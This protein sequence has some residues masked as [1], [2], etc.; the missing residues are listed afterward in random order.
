MSD[1]IKKIKTA[2]GE[3]QIDYTALANLPNQYTCTGQNEDGW[4]TQKAVTDYLA[5]AVEETKAYIDST[6]SGIVTAT[7]E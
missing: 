5:A 1:Y 6:V 7:V 2:D 4:M 3:K